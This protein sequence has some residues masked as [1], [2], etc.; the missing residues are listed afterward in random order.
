VKENTL[1][2]QRLSS[3]AA[4]RLGSVPSIPA[5]PSLRLSPEVLVLG[6][7]CTLDMLTT[8]YW[9]KNGIATE[10]NPL[11]RGHAEHGLLSFFLV[12]LLSFVPALALAEWYGRR[13]PEFIR[14]LLRLAGVVYLGVYVALVG[15]QFLG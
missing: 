8:A 1:Q 3:R 10:A 7:I 2:A 9:L 13:R 6:L 12:K 15:K 14:P 11:L 5:L 4:V